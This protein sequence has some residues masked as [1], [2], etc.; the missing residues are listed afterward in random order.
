MGFTLLDLFQAHSSSCAP[1]ICWTTWQHKGA[2]ERWIQYSH[3]CQLT[4]IYTFHATNDD[5]HGTLGTWWR[6]YS[7]YTWN[8]TERSQ[9]CGIELS[10]TLHIHRRLFKLR[11]FQIWN[12]RGYNYTSTHHSCWM[13]VSIHSTDNANLQDLL[14]YGTIIIECYHIPR[15]IWRKKVNSKIFHDQ[16]LLRITPT[17]KNRKKDSL[18]NQSYW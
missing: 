2:K 14:L 9:T 13:H 16:Q 6:I 18:R 8:N 3:W 1:S 7:C 11:Y 15:Q 12:M 4:D 5:A 17:G 10:K